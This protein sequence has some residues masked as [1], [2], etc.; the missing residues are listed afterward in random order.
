MSKVLRA[1]F[2]A[3]LNEA[4]LSIPKRVPAEWVVDCKHVE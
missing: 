1:R 4:G 3:A 2:L